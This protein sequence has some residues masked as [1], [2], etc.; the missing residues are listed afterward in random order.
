MAFA[1]VDPGL[2][3]ANLHAST[4]PRQAAAEVRHAAETAID[5]AGESA[6]ILGGDFNVRPNQTPLFEELAQR[7]GLGAPTGPDAIDH[8]LGARARDRR[9]AER[10]ATRGAGAAVRGPPAAPQ[11]PCAGRSPVRHPLMVNPRGTRE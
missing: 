6:L 3:V 10:L 2:C 7:F 4:N 8:I 5:W 9:P 1:R 11:R